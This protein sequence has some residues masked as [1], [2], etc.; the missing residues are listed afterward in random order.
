[1]KAIQIQK[2]TK[3]LNVWLNDIDIPIITDDEI[4][5]KVEY[6]A[7]NP[8]DILIMNGS[9][10]L[11]Q[12]YKFPLTLGSECSGIIE[13]IGKNVNDFKI[14]DRVYAYL[15]LNKIGAFAEFVAIH[16]NA[17]AK[18]P[19]N[20]DAKTATS[21]P[22]AGLS[23]Y[24]ALV[25]ELDVQPKQT[26]LILGGSGSFGQ[27]AVPIM[28]SFDINTIVVGN[29]KSLQYF[30]NLGVNQYI[31]YRQQKY[32]EILKDID[33]V[34]DTL[35]EFDNALSV[36]KQH[37]CLLSLKNIPNKAFCDK[38]NITGIKKILFSMAGYKLD[39]I[40][41][42]QKKLYRF[43]FVKANGDWLKKVTA[44]MQK[45]TIAPRIHNHD[46]TLQTFNEALQT[47]NS[48]NYEGKIIITIN[49]CT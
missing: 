26:I 31:D 34:I 13:K 24:Q 3:T 10:K 7:L 15:P 20:Y 33:Y 45:T 48:G 19:I 23:I 9:L 14:G 38:N 21:I 22:L 28:K 5:L 11:I 6:A 4:L 40:A 35:G 36:L 25:D 39:K 2:Y 1:M 46:F 43:M 16:K 32:W 29:A 44:I 42:R 47:L 37:G 18:I 8:L 12:S 27:I 41:T 49:P 17:I 30:N